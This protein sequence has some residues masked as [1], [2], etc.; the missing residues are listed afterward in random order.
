MAASA[1]KIAVEEDAASPTEGL[2]ATLLEHITAKQGFSEANA[3][4]SI[5]NRLI[6]VSK[7]GKDHRTDEGLI[8]IGV[9][10]PPPPPPPPPTPHARQLGSL[11]I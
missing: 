8:A 1:I 7:H 9:T 6:I 10:R 11:G 3:P 2:G 4:E 5:T